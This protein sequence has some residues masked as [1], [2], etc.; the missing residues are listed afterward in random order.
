MDP[1]AGLQTLAGTPFDIR[2]I[3]QLVSSHPHLA[4]HFPPA[5][6]GIRVR[7][8][9]LG[10]NFLHATCFA[11]TNGE[12]SAEYIIHYDNGLRHS[13]PVVYGQNI[14]DWWYLPSTPPALNADTV[15]AWQ[16][17][18]PHSRR[19]GCGVQLY[20]FHW[21]NPHPEAVIATID[22]K[23]TKAGPAPFLIAITA[24]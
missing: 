18:N 21:V 19:A 13:I 16:G 4:Q 20:K 2:G 17:A 3:I 8:R 14:S 23:S 5:V 6:N 7:Q 24:E 9:C 11:G 1:P 12:T 15:V 10:L 22:L